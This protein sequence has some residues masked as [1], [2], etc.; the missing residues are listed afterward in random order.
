M[1]Y[2][3][4]FAKFHLEPIRAPKP[5]TQPLPGLTRTR[6]GFSELQ[7]S[8]GGIGRRY[9]LISRWPRGTMGAYPHVLLE[10]FV[11]D[12]GKVDDLTRP[13]FEYPPQERSA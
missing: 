1:T 2:P 3:F 9:T 8:D 5:I 12:S 4:D 11:L 10:L 7:I 13:P 6:G